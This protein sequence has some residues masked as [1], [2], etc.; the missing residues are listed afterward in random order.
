MISLTR[1]SKVSSNTTET[2]HEFK[3]AR[4]YRPPPLLVI[5]IVQAALSL[6]LIW[7]NTAFM[8]EGLYLWAG[9]LEWAHWLHGAAITPYGFPLYFSGAPV[10]YPPLGALA[11]DAG[12]LAGARIL[13][14]CFMLGATALLYSVTQ[15]LTFNRRAA[16]AA[17]VV[18][19]FLGPTQYPR[20]IRHL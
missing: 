10:I 3:T 8:D 17:A 4:W 5:L 20:C 18:F 13:S 2:V 19:A 12:G 16:T 7:S 9:R 15:R 6:R 14:L 1:P 11:N